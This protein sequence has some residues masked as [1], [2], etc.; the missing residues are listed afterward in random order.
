MVTLAPAEW[1]REV[2]ALGRIPI[3][4]PEENPRTQPRGWVQRAAL[5]VPTWAWVLLVTVLIGTLLVVG[6]FM[7]QSDLE[8]RAGAVTPPAEPDVTLPSGN[9]R[10]RWGLS[11]LY[12]GINPQDYIVLVPPIQAVTWTYT[13]SADGTGGTLVAASAPPGRM[14]S[15][16]PTRV[17]PLYLTVSETSDPVSTG[18]WVMVRDPLNDPNRGGTLANTA[19]GGCAQAPFN[20]AAGDAVLLDV[21]CSPASIAWYFESEPAVI[22]PV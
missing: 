14:L 3:T 20:A 22:S 16:G 1:E 13:R 6:F 19:L 4:A 18:S 5:R 8:R 9:Y 15:A 21:T 11:E 17:V 2:Q 12:L 10:L 7:Y